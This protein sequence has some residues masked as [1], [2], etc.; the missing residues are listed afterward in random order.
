MA[1]LLLVSLQF[2]RVISL[3]L[4]GFLAFG[5]VALAVF[6]KIAMYFW[7]YKE[8]QKNEKLDAAEG[9]IEGRRRVDEARRLLNTD[10]EYR[11][12]LRERFRRKDGN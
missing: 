7:A 10:D 11:E 8:G 12:R 2:L 4:Q 1:W 6:L 3:M 9:H 5:R